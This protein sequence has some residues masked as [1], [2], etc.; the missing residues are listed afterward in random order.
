MYLVVE[1]LPQ[2]RRVVKAT[3]LAARAGLWQTLGRIAQ[4]PA[5]D[6]DSTP[7]RLLPPLYRMSNMIRAESEGLPLYFFPSLKRIPGLVHGVTTRSG[8]E[9]R[10]PAAGF[11]LAPGKEPVEQTGENLE[12]LRNALGLDALA[13]VRQVHG[14]KVVRIN[15]GEPFPAC[16]ADGLMTDRPGVGLLIKQADCQALVLAAPGKAVGNFHVGWRGNVAGFPKKAVAVFC[17]EF[18]LKPAELHAAVSPAWGPAAASSQTT[19]R[20]FPATS[21]PSRWGRAISICGP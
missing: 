14:D 10:D 2:P 20:S 16:E 17:R 18:G 5:K 4:A 12:H 7:R 21:G 1:T 8:G 13:S 11:N 19:A 15:G 6:P 3:E 9:G